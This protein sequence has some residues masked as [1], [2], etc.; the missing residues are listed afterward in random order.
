MQFTGKYFN[1]NHELT[2]KN[3]YKILPLH[4]DVPVITVLRN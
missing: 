4:E 1:Y 2:I 3:S